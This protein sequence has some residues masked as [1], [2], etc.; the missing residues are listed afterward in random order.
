MMKNVRVI[1]LANSWRGLVGSVVREETLILKNLGNDCLTTDKFKIES[2]ILF[3]DNCD[4]HFLHRYI[5]NCFPKVKTV[6]LNSHPHQ[7]TVL[8]HLRYM[9]L[10]KDVFVYVH[11]SYWKHVKNC[12]PNSTFYRLSSRQYKRILSNYETKV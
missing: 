1:D 5:P 12:F 3:L 9:T 6:Y 4:R 8:E 10:T 11:E 2:K 7:C